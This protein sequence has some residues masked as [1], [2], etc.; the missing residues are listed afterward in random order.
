MT[1]VG[2]IEKKTQDRVVALFRDTLGYTDLGDW[3]DRDN[4]RNIEPTLLRAWLEKQKYAPALIEKALR[5][6]D[7]AASDASKSLYDRNRA[8]YTLLRYGVKVAARSR[9]EHP[10]RLPAGLEEPA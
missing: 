7:Q 2:Q 9:R 3:R 1:T 4:N 6:L 8:V 10:N 5:E